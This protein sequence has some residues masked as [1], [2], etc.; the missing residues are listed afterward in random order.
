MNHKCY[1]MNGGRGERG[2]GMGVW[3]DWWVEGMKKSKGGLITVSNRKRGSE[4]KPA[5][6]IESD[7]NFGSIACL[8]S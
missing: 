5:G 4:S 2:E 6:V 8:F 1:T 3:V 7:L